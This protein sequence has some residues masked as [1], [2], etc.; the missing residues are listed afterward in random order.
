ML[1][2]FVALASFLSQRLGRDERGATAVEYGL[3]VALIA[4]PKSMMPKTSNS[5]SGSSNANSTA[6]AP[7]SPT[8]M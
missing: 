3:M 4:R 7:R 1:N 6:A 2:C 5:N 8:R